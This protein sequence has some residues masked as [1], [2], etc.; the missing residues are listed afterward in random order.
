VE[1]VVA[2]A[3]AIKDLAGADRAA[4]GMCGDLCELRFRESG[5][6]TVE[7]GRLYIHGLSRYRS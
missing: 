3:F 2:V 4:L 6:R 1:V 7:V 5:S